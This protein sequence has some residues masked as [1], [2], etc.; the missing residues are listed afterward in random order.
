MAI[1]VRIDALLEKHGQTAYWLAKEANLTHSAIWRLRHG[2]ASSISF[3]IM[4]KLCR[5]LDCT[6][7]D[8]FVVDS[9]KKVKR[10]N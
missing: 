10:G 6:P 8:L 9:G 7:G 4:E 1:E 2:K 5:A 3:E